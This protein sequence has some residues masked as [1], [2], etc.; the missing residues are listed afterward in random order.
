MWCD[1]CGLDGAVE[2][3]E[4]R[5]DYVAY[6]AESKVTKICAECDGREHWLYARK[7]REEEAQRQEDARAVAP[8][9]SPSY[10]TPRSVRGA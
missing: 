8:R 5:E 3:A 6:L 7:I 2:M 9:P 4:K 1:I 10:G